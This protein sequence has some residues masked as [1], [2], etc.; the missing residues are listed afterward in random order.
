M[1]GYYHALI[2]RKVWAGNSPDLPDIVCRFVQWKNK[3]E[4]T[5]M[6][7][8]T[9]SHYKILEKLGSGGMGTVYKAMDTKLDRFVALKFLAPYLSQAEEAKKRF[10]HEARAVSALDHPNICNIYEID[11]TSDGQMVIVM[12]HCDYHALHKNR[13]MNFGLSRSTSFLCFPV[14]LQQEN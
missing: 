7:G 9:I 8:R 1:K 14:I 6:I 10:I 13:I 12:I 5:E 3:L 4:A 2:L 11:E